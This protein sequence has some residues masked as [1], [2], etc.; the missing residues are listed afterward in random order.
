MKQKI[1]YYVVWKGRKTGVFDTWD[2][3]SKQIS[4]FQG[5]RYKSY[6]AMDEAKEAFEKGAPIPVQ[7]KKRE[8]IQSRPSEMSICVDAACS[9]A[10]M[11]MEYRGVFYP[12]GKVLFHKGPFEG[13]SNNIGEFLAIVH[14]LSY[15]KKSGLYFPVYSD[16]LTAIAWVRKKMINTKIDMSPKVTEITQKAVKWL[17]KN[18]IENYQI[19]KWETS[20][21]GEIPADFGRK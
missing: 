11:V 3:C 9:V 12:S 5:A 16:S 19:R 18:S 7:S 1:K 4:G 13:A 21:W 8:F 2:E 15:M 14:A 10:K 17:H 6:S 20:V